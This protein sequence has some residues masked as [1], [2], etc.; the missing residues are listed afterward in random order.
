[1]NRNKQASTGIIT[2]IETF[3]TRDGPGIRTTVFV[4]G[5]PLRC[6]WCSNPE[7]WTPYPQL[8]FHAKRC[9]DYGKCVKV[10]P[11]DAVSMD[12]AQKID[13]QKCTL[14]ML[15]VEACNYDALVKVGAEVTTE[16]VAERV[17]KDYPFYVR[18]NGGV[19][20]SGGEPLSQPDFTLEL[21]KI[22]HEKGIHTCL[23]TSGYAKPEDVKR[24]IK[25]VD[26]V[27]LDIKHMDPAKHTEW[28][29][30]SN[31]LILKNAELMANECEMRASLPL[32]SGVNDSDE[33]I[34]R[35]AE[36]A[37]SLG[38]GSIDVEPFHKL[39]EGKYLALGLKSPYSDLKEVSSEKVNHVMEMIESYGLKTTRGRAIR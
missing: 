3:A 17:E 11:E 37:A 30:V 15:C 24:V 14:C 36:F 13:R 39:G 8:Y 28:T 25:H 35:T 31:E 23:D 34:E 26:L 21:L 22:C 32:I 16:E 1:M 7:T 5:C 4:K 20:I 19:T 33:N 9:K 18:S 38:I 29:G 27:L 6:R 10:C 2:E 12:K